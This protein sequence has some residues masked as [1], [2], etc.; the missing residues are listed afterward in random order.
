MTDIADWWPMLH[1]Q[2]RRVIV[3]GLWSPIASFSL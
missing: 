2:I 3:N 1:E